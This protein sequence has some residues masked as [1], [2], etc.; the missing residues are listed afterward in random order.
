[1]R[2]SDNGTLIFEPGEIVRM[3]PIPVGT[4]L[5]RFTDI[6]DCLQWQPVYGLHESTVHEGQRALRIC[7][8]GDC[9]RIIRQ[10]EFP[11]ISVWF[12]K[13]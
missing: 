2:V 11:R 13:L 6:I 4:V 5:S 12:E 1:M 10:E 3:S 8:T 7:D 9:Y